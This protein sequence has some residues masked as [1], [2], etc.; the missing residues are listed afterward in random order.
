MMRCCDGNLSAV[1]LS[2]NAVYNQILLEILNH[3]LQISSEATG[4]S[5][6]K[7]KE[8]NNLTPCG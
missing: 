3:A 5:K 2:K 1:W 6:A 8:D 4:R 7:T